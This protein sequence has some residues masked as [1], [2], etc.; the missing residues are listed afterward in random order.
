M[1]TKKSGSA[2]LE[3]QRT[4][5]FLLGLVLVMALMFVAFE[6][7]AHDNGGSDG[8][9]V[10]DDIPTDAEM[11]PPTVPPDAVPLMPKSRKAAEAVRITAVSDSKEAAEI[12]QPADTGDEDSPFDEGNAAGGGDGSG[13]DAQ[14]EAIPSVATG[15]D[16]NPLN[17]HVV[18]DLPQFPGG[19]VELMKWLTRNLRYPT[20]IQ[21]QKVEGKVVV[22]FYINRDGSV[23]GLKLVQTLHPACDREAMRV[24]RMMPK[25]KP[26]V[27]HDK[28]CR[29]MVRIPIV[30]KSNGNKT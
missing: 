18:E 14:T 17:F 29:T 10:L 13:D 5:R 30:F 21:K 4:T 7:T 28:P 24:M 1:E 3:N 15:T 25:W 27:Q 19:A 20:A 9:E 26:G 12:P 6:Y 22:Q 16:G 23:S 2:D 8:S 11:L